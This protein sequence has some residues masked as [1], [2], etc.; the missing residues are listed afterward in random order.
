MIMH[1][2]VR[3][4]MH[5]FLSVSM[6]V[7][8]GVQQMALPEQFPIGQNVGRSSFAD[9]AP[10]VQDVNIIRN[11]LDDVQVVRGGDDC[12]RRGAAL[13]QE[14]DHFALTFRIKR[15][16][17]FVEQQHFGLQDEDRGQRHPFL[18]TTR[19][20]VRRP[21]VTTGTSRRKAAVYSRVSRKSGQTA[22]K[23]D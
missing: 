6:N 1:M 9:H 3:M 16:G 14:S 18:F 10:P 8:M 2:P 15:G 13:D 4:R 11:F 19:E 7:Q 17:R 5:V 22:M 20:T 23:P 21:A 12:A